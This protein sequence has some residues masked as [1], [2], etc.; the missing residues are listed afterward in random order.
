MIYIIPSRAS[1]KQCWGLQWL[2]KM[3]TLWPRF[4]KPTAASTINLSAPPMPRSGWKKAMVFPLAGCDMSGHRRGITRSI[5]VFVGCEDTLARAFQPRASEVRASLNARDGEAASLVQP[6]RSAN[7]SSLHLPVER[8]RIKSHYLYQRLPFRRGEH[9]RGCSS[10]GMQK[11]NHNHS[12]K[13]TCIT[14]TA[15]DNTN[16]G[17]ATTS[18]SIPSASSSTVAAANM[19]AEWRSSAAIL[20]GVFSFMML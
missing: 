14:S 20:A 4:C 2:V 16:T 6:C 9:F 11:I 15:A 5:A 18:M 1:S 13:H 7:L 3:T 8:P 12:L 17:S 19:K 10:R